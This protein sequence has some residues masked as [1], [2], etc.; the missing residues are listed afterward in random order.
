VP[1]GIGGEFEIQVGLGSA[2]AGAASAARKKAR[3]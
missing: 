2:P 1:P 3:S